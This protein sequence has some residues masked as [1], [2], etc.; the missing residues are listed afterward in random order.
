[1]SDMQ[2]GA[3]FVMLVVGIPGVIAAV[4]PPRVSKRIRIAGMVWVV[5][6]WLPPLTLIWIKG[7][8]G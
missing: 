5:F 1:V 8:F 6:W 2:F 3:L 4:E 7:V